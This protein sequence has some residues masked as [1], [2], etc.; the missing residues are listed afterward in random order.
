MSI[1]TPEELKQKL[2]A[3]YNHIF[4]EGKEVGREHAKEILHKD[5]AEAAAAEVAR[6]R[7]IEEAKKFEDRVAAF[8]AEGLS[9]GAAIVRAAREF[10]DAHSDYIRRAQDG[11]APALR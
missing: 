5:T 10:P 9:L 11:K 3:V 8:K 7:G 4:S 2:P 6:V 1:M